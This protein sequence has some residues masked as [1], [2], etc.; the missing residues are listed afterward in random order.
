[1]EQNR[2]LYLSRPIIQASL[3][4]KVLCLEA[5]FAG[6]VTGASMN[7]IRSLAPAVVSGQLDHLWLYL[8]AP[9]LGAVLAFPTC[10]LIQGEGCC[11]TEANPAEAS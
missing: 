6:P 2:F 9:T 10:K 5:L 4:R 8:V 1:M 11:D 3:V 7:P